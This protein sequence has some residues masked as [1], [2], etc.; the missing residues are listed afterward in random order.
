MKKIGILFIILNLLMLISC[1]TATSIKC[2][3]CDGGGECTGCGGDGIRGEQTCSLCGGSGECKYCYGTGEFNI[4]DS[5]KQNNNPKNTP[6]FELIIL[7]CTIALL[8]FL[9]RNRKF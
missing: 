3:V 2:Q 7:I 4:E 6:G 8:L 5:D 9:K 1:N